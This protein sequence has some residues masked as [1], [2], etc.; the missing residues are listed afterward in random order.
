MCLYI[1]IVSTFQLSYVM[2]LTPVILP[3]SGSKTSALKM[4]KNVIVNGQQKQLTLAEYHHD[5]Q[6]RRLQL[7]HKQQMHYGPFLNY[8]YK[9]PSATETHGNHIFC[10]KK[11]LNPL[12]GM[13]LV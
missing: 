3:T 6:A 12:Y 1:S 9:R 5:I 11:F 7:K 8:L 10:L 4:D 13:D 2:Q